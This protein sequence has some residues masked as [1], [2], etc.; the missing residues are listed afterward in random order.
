MKKLIIFDVDGTILDTIETITYHVNKMLK[1]LDLEAVSSSFTGGILGYSSKYLIEKVLDHKGYSYDEEEL[2]RLLDV[3]HKSYQSEVAYLTKPY[4][5]IVH[6]LEK[7]KDEGLFLAALSNKPHHTLSVLFKEI[8]FNKYFDYVIGQRDDVPKKPSP[9]MVFEIMDKF[10]LDKDDLCMI[11]DTEVDYETAK[12]AKI[13]FIAVTW[14]FR[15]KDELL[16]LNPEFIAD[17]VTELGALIDREDV[18]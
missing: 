2:E 1:T 4:S 17:D 14:G 8:D 12:N 9:D 16:E 11:G 5:G 10:D 15:T 3:Y 13:E 7:L 18:L 6:L